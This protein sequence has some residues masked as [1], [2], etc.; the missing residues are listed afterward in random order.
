MRIR[1]IAALL[2]GLTALSAVFVAAQDNPGPPHPK[3][4][5]LVFTRSAG[6]KHACIPVLEK[7][8]TDLGSS[9]GAFAATVTQDPEAFTPGNL[10]GY[11]AVFFYTTRDVL[12]KPEQRKALFDFVKGGKGFIGSHCATD[13]LYGPG[14]KEGETPCPEYGEMIGAYFDGHPWG[15]GS[16]VTIKVE[17][18]THPATKGLPGSW[19]LPDEIYQ[20]QEFSRERVHVLM[21]LDAEKMDVSKGKRADKDYAIAW[22]RKYGEGRV[23]YTALG[24]MEEHWNDRETFLGKHILPAIRWAMGDEAWEMP[25]K[26]N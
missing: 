24:H 8:L 11:D 9:S 5:L 14:V 23:F 21:S 26:A 16:K 19:E 17:D 3:R 22:C 18:A 10:A 4:K 20:F 15:A 25:K 13:T 2:S 1:P 12:P 7:A 6:F